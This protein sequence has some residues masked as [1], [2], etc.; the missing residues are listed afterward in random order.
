[1][2]NPV[3]MEEFPALSLDKVRGILTVRFSDR[4]EFYAVPPGT[5]M[6]ALVAGGLDKILAFPRLEFKDSKPCPAAAF[7]YLNG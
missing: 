3:V 2:P 7:R 1:M 4:K 5:T 6:A